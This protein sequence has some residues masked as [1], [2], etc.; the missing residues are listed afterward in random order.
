MYYIR[1][2]YVVYSFSIYL[3]RKFRFRVRSRVILPG[4]YLPRGHPIYPA[5]ENCK[6]SRAARAGAIT[7]EIIYRDRAG[8]HLS[9][10]ISGRVSAR[11]RNP[12]LLTYP[13]VRKI[14]LLRERIL[15]KLRSHH[16]AA[17]FLRRILRLPLSLLFRDKLAQTSCRQHYDSLI[18]S[19][20][21]F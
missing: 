16:P 3:I 18:R 1:I 8:L 4:K 2:L 11:A 13:R 9:G 10:G 15:M 7:N 14:D 19:R 5:H 12:R 20:V 6:R 21:K 17:R